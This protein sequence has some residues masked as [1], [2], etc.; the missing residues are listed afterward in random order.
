MSHLG[1]NNDGAFV[2]VD[3]IFKIIVEQIMFRS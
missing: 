2:K 1:Y 3:G